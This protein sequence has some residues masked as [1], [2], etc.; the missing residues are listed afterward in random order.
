M[1][2]MELPNFCVH[3]IVLR[4]FFFFKVKQVAQILK[5]VVIFN[6]GNEEVVYIAKTG[7]ISRSISDARNVY[8]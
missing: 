1:Y 4:Q 6:F 3:R 8:F 5:R 7:Y 2:K